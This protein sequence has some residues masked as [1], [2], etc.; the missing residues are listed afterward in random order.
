MFLFIGILIGF[1]LSV[2]I[3]LAEAREARLKGRTGTR[4]RTRLKL[5]DYATMTWR[6][7]VFLLVPIAIGL[8]L[9]VAFGTTIGEIGEG[10]SEGDLIQ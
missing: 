7:G 1:N 8:L 10:L 4:G 9:D 5:G 2:R 6:G 3:V